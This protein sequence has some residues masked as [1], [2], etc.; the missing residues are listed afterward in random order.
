MARTACSYPQGLPSRECTIIQQVT[1]GSGTTMGSRHQGA[2]SIGL[3][4]V[5]C[6]DVP[7][8]STVVLEKPRVIVRERPMENA[9]SSWGQF[10][11]GK[12]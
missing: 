6:E 10:D 5:G 9:H 12:E 4:C 1:I 3:N 8:I 11:K 7:I 2:P